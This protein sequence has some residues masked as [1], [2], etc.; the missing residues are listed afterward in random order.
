[1]TESLPPL[2]IHCRFYEQRWR[3]G[4]RTCHRRKERSYL[5]RDPVTGH[6]ERVEKKRFCRDER[7]DR[8]F[9]ILSPDAC[10]PEGRHFQP[11]ADAAP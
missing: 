3:G 5:K 6:E 4:D 1:M 8:R 9:N 10:G 2:C 7:A 11:K